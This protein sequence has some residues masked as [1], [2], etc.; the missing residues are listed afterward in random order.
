MQLDK[1][2]IAVRERS[3]FDTLDL[4]LQMFRIYIWPLSV[5]MLFGALP[6]AVLNHTLIGWMLSDV[7]LDVPVA[8]EEMGGTSRYLWTM[9]LLVVIEAPL[10][11]AL[12]TSYLGKIVFVD[13]PRI[14]QVVREMIPLAPRLVWCHL[15]LRG[16]LPALFLVLSIG[17]ES[18]LSGTEVLLG[19][20][21]VAI[22]LRRATAPF[23]NEIILLERNPIRA[24]RRDTMTIRKRSGMLHGSAGGNLLNLSL[25]SGLLAVFLALSLFGTM[26]CLQGIFFDNWSLGKGILVI[27]TP[28]SLWITAEFFAVVRFLSYLD[29]RIRHEGWEVELRSA[30]KAV[31]WRSRYHD[32]VVVRELHP[33]TCPGTPGRSGTT[34]G[35]GYRRSD[36]A[37][38]VAAAIRPALVRS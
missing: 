11:S 36:G 35:P 27:G 30:L 17:R 5:T 10:A 34:G 15:L 31:D 14:W 38:S 20:M 25:T 24:V 32:G 26:L 33:V 28:L 21:F 6:L 16:V 12:V 37:G 1:T 9:I 19:L 29:L 18:R 2:R 8:V 22:M 3:L 13:R 23:M 4:S 7:D